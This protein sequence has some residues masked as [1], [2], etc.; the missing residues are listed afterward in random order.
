MF[1]QGHLAAGRLKR[2]GAIVD[3]S[4]R[5]KA[6]SMY[7]GLAFYIIFLY[8]NRGTNLSRGVQ[9]IGSRVAF[10][11]KPEP[12]GCFYF[13]SRAIV[14][15]ISSP[16][17]RA[18]KVFSSMSK[19]SWQRPMTFSMSFG[20]TTT[21]P[22]LSPTRISPGL[23]HRSSLNWSGTSISEA[24]VNVLDPKMEVSRANT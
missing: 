20:G 18:A 4:R 9:A 5:S 23:I 24:R 6:L 3:T 11:S 13:R 7:K 1:Y 15:P 8:F 2:N 14:G 21:T 19:R 10:M 16:F 22:S 12:S 17:R